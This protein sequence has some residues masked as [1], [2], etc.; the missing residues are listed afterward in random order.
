MG[1]TA[2]PSGGSPY[3]AVDAG[4]VFTKAYVLD[5]V[6]GERRLVAVGRAPSDGDDGHPAR[7]QAVARAV[8]QALAIGGY[9]GD[10]RTDVAVTLRTHVPRV[11]VAA[12]REDAAREAAEQIERLPVRVV[13]RVALAG[14]A[15]GAERLLGALEELTPDALIIVA[16][17]DGRG[18][19]GKATLGALEALRFSGLAPF[20]VL[21]GQIPEGAALLDGVRHAVAPAADG[22]AVAAALAP[23]VE[24]SSLDGV[25]VGTEI[26]AERY[27]VDVLTL[28]LGASHAVA[29]LAS[30]TTGRRRVVAVARDDLGLRRGRPEILAKAGVE[31]LLRWLPIDVDGEALRSDARRGLIAPAALPETPEELLL[32]HAFAREALR[33]L[34]ADLPKGVAGGAAGLPPVDLVIG[35]GGPLAGA[36][37]LSQAAMILLDAVQPEALTQLALDR[38]TAL[39]LLGHLGASAGHA[40]VGAA[41][42]RDGLLNLGLC[43]APIGSGREGETAVRVEVAFATRSPVTVEVPF[44][45]IEVV[46]LGIGERASLKLWPSRDFDVGLGRGNAATPRAE[47]EGGAVGIIID[48]R[49]RPL[50]LP[51]AREKRQA[52]LL[53]WLQATRAYPQ[54][55]F[56][57]PEE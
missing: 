46:P 49:G 16:A 38:A 33:L 15:G 18:A 56:V 23:L 37:R 4:S 24:A 8:A 2:G 20:V 12:A 19:E 40:N 41:L 57:Q 55:S 30:G 45:A 29:V 52:K 27:D 54:L 43:I 22:A 11:V 26:V 3:V 9:S 28:D 13:E 35:S 17:A 6:D 25:R 42:E 14:G 5:D 51:D 53:Q 10:A 36:P 21:V 50:A 47:V 7:D 34:L 32:E 44:G 1:T 48:A 39:P 31:A